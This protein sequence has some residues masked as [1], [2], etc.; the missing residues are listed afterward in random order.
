MAEQKTPTVR[1]AVGVFP[2]ERALQAAVDDLLSHGFDRS[3]LSL[4]APLSSVQKELGHGFASV[5]ELEDDATVP[6]TAYI[7][8]NTI[9]DAEGGVFGG[10]IYV[11]ALATL[12]AVVASIIAAAAGGVG[13]G[14]IG[15][16]L[17]KIIGQHHADYVEEQLERGGL[18]LWVRTWSAADEKHAIEILANHSGSD[19]HV[20]DLP[21][22]HAALEERYNGAEFAGELQAYR[23]VPY[24]FLPSG[25]YYIAGEVLPTEQDVKARIDRDIDREKLRSEAKA[26]NWDIEALLG[27][28]ASIFPSP[29]K[30]LA[31]ELPLSIQ[32]DILKRWAY[33]EKQ[34]EIASDDGMKPAQ[35]GDRLQEINL[36][37]ER[38]QAR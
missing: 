20:H 33:G 26:Q 6:T 12:T 30:L 4:L 11:G 22:T 19:V 2:S 37:L 21:A 25:E 9:G 5:T 7:S 27:N 34:L 13:G 32:R 38:L 10:F 18:L 31:T 3:E 14:A 28:P 16:V 29:A 24:S 15:G 23:G 17:A 8:T 36:A 35:N 1:E